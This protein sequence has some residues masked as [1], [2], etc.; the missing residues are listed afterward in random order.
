MN[1]EHRIARLTASHVCSE[2]TV[3][4]LSIEAMPLHTPPPTTGS[5]D[6]TCNTGAAK[7]HSPHFYS[8]VLTTSATEYLSS[9]KSHLHSY[10]VFSFPFYDSSL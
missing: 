4:S 9:F 10:L 8:A 5:V 1:N 3:N 7:V 6:N 2:D